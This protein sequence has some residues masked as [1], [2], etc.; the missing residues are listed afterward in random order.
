VLELE[1][2]GVRSDLHQRI[3]QDLA[4]LGIDKEKG[5]SDGFQAPPAPSSPAVVRSLPGWP[6]RNRDNYYRSS[7]AAN[8]ASEMGSVVVETYLPK[9]T[10]INLGESVS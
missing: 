4:D 1:E 10:F 8:P 3:A 9:N 2:S 5:V 6:H 7:S